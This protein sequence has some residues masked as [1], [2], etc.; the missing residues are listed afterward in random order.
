MR[1]WSFLF[2]GRRDF[3]NNHR[4]RVPINP[5]QRRTLEMRDEVLSS[6]GAQNMDTSEYAGK[7]QADHILIFTIL[8]STGRM[9]SWMQTLSLD[10]ELLPL[11]SPLAFDELQKRG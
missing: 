9:I 1:T 6:V 10:Q 11:S 2:S 3:L 7:T 5:K 4:A 8:I